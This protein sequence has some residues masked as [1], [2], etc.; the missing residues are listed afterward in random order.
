[1]V[2]RRDSL[3]QGW[4][5]TGFLC[6]QVEPA[7]YLELTGTSFG[8]HSHEAGERVGRHRFKTNHVY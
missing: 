2:R 4:R 7:H 5:V 8:G 6:C 3:T 1:M